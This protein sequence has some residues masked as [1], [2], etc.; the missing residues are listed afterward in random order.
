MDTE[1]PKIR[2]DLEF[3]PAQSAGR[4]VIVVHDRLGLVEKG[5][6]ISP[7]LYQAMTMLDGTRSIRDLQ[8]ELIRRQGGRLISIEEVD[9]L[10]ARLDSSY[11][12]DSQRYRGAKNE[13]VSNFSAQKIRYCSH[14]G[15][16]YPKQ[17]EELTR[18]LETILATQQ[19]PSLPHDK[20][21]ALVAPHIDLEAGKRLYSS[22]YRAVE[23]VAAKR[24]IIIGVGHSMGEQMFSLTKK[25]FETPL[26]RVAT[27]QEIV[28]ELMKA[29]GGV[30]S[31]DDSAHRDE[32]SIEF[33][34][35]FMQHI[36]R[37]GSFTIV[38]ILCGFLRG[39]LPDYSRETYQSEARDLL[40]ILA[41]AA[42]DEGTILIAGVD[43]SHVGPKFGH[44]MPASFIIDQSERHDRQLLD[45]LCARNADGF[46]SESRRIED[47]FNVCGFSALACLLETLPPSQGH[48]LGYEIFREDSTR[49]AV[50]FAAAIFTNTAGSRM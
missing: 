44:D 40:R 17:E 27:D 21:T 38:P 41:D 5:K 18:R 6:G 3:F 30:V 19:V 32:H 37:E 10:L 24:L 12:L 33:Q 14:A 4:M 31:T 13:I 8:I 50:S 7:E 28:R 36:L 22:A 25:A 48:L 1:K 20:I 46:W 15:V 11:L 9:A 43:L 23:G 16:S 35:I 49:S 29:G 45:F 2:E 39:C 34:L 47:K 26:G 42:R